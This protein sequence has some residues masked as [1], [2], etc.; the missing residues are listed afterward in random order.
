MDGYRIEATRFTESRLQTDS[1]SPQ[2]FNPYGFSHRREQGPP[3]ARVLT[4]QVAGRL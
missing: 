2:S 1:L 4:L 3:S